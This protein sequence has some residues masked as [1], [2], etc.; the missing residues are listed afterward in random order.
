VVYLPETQLLF[1]VDLWAPG[2]IPL[3]QPLPAGFYRTG[4]LDLS[5]F[6]EVD[7]IDVE[8]IAGGHG[9]VGPLSDLRKHLGRD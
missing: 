3:D 6:I 2:Q 5:N 8:M 1:N 7:E 4:A 9:S